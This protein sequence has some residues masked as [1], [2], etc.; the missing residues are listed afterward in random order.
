[1]QIRHARDLM[2]PIGQYPHVSVDATI[3]EAIEMFLD[4]SHDIEVNDGRKSLPRVLLVIGGDHELIGILRRRDIMRGLEPGFLHSSRVDAESGIF[5]V[6]HDP[7]LAEFSYDHMLGP[8]KARA[9]KPIGKIMQPILITVRE[10]DHLFKV[11]D[12]MV[13]N[14]VSLVPVVEHG[15]ITGAIRSVDVLEEIAR[16][17]R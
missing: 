5:G 17:I 3:A 13:D 1:M 12:A 2:I 10:D 15:R 14:N 4:G 16:L 6:R 7:D 8:M 11:I 9:R